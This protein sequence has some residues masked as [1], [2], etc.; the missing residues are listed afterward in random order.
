MPENVTVAFINGQSLDELI[1]DMCL[2]NVKCYIPKNLTVHGVSTVFLKPVTTF[3]FNKIIT[4]INNN[5][6]TTSSPGR[7][8]HPE[9]N[10]LTSQNL[11]DY[12]SYL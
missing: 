1:K 3:H 2:V 11:R 10:L 4:I 9:D 6:S 7:S 5:T 8:G 12:A